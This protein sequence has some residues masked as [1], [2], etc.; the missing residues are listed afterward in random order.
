MSLTIGITG[1]VCSGKSVVCSLLAEKGIPVFSADEFARK[2]VEPGTTPYKE[3]VSRFGTD[4]LLPD[5]SLDRPKLRR[6]MISDN[7]VKQTLED[8][9]HPE[10]IRLMGTCLEDARKNGNP[11]CGVEVPLLFESGFSRFFDLIVTVTV[12]PEIRIRRL[13]ARDGVSRFQAIALLKLQMPDADKIKQSDFVIKNNESMEELK[14]AVDR[15]YQE[16]M[17]HL[18]NC[19]KKS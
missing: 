2:A 15:F 16:L 10:V 8:L 4:I 14:D 9:I 18:K 17:H 7:T 13:M 3:I 12:E 5:G 19:N 6:M 1:G 11:L